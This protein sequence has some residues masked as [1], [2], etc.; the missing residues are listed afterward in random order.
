ML[1][2]HGSLDESTGDFLR[3]RPL[4][5]RESVVGKLHA[6]DIVERPPEKIVARV[7]ADEAGV[8]AVLYPHLA[9]DEQLVGIMESAVGSVAHRHADA[10]LPGLSP[11]RLGVVEHI[12]PVD[13]IDVG[14]PDTPIGHE[15]HG[16]G[17]IG[18]GRSGVSPCHQVLRP[19][20]GHV[21]RILCG[22]EIEIAIVGLDDRW[23][24]HA[25][26]NHRIVVY[27]GA[28]VGMGTRHGAQCQT[29]GHGVSHH[30]TI[31]TQYQLAGSNFVHI[32]S[33][34]RHSVSV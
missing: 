32:S 2:D 15:V 10:T 7:D 8:D 16:A 3:L 12:L 33:A 29:N 4:H 23:V 1:H 5:D 25:V 9:R 13:V 21:V 34:S 22:I 30:S 11:L 31:H 26:S 19:V 6:V 20:D 17:G 28:I 18:E 27:H 24:G 14:S